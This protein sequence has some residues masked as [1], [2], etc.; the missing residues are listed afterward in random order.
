MSEGDGNEE[1]REQGYQLSNIRD[2][3]VV[4][5]KSNEER[6]QIKDRY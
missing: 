3:N 2:K 4:Q 5:I 1:E 6:Q